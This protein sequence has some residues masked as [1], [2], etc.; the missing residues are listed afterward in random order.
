MSK[1]T[2]K[3]TAETATGTEIALVGAEQKATR[4]RAPK[5]KATESKPAPK[6]EP[7]PTPA[8]DTEE[9]VVFA[10][11]LTRPERDAIHEAAG[12]G[13]ASRFVK[14]LA[15]AAATGDID[16]IHTLV[17]GVVRRK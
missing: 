16:T 5:A 15:V 3:T 8:E 7:D 1:R 13:K 14:T 9:L 11:R 6:A 2:K 12:S 4:K 17:G 10:F